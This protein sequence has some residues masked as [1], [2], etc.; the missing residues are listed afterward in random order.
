VTGDPTDTVVEYIQ[1]FPV[2]SVTPTEGQIL[3]FI[4]GVWT[5]TTSALVTPPSGVQWDG[6]GTVWDTGG[7]TWSA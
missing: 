7:T 3:M 1:R 5:P 6:G 4:S 2:A